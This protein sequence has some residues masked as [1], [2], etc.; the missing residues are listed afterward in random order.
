MLVVFF[1]ATLSSC[2]NGRLDNCVGH[3][4][5]CICPETIKENEK[6]LAL[7]DADILGHAVA[8]SE[9]RKHNCCGDNICSGPE[10][11]ANCVADCPGVT[12]DATCGEEPHSDRGGRTLTFGVGHRA[13]SAQ[14]CCDKCKAHPKH[15]NSW[16]FCGVAVCWG[17]DTG[18]NH[19]FG[20]CWLRKL[21][22]PA[23]PTFG[24]RGIFAASYRKKMLRTR[25]HLRKPR[26]SAES[27]ELSTSSKCRE[28]IHTSTVFVLATVLLAYSMG[29]AAALAVSTRASS[30]VHATSN[31]AFSC[32]DA[33][34]R[35]LI[36]DAVVASDTVTVPF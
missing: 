32:A 5:K 30:H 22:D 31:T 3:P 17:L 21:E 1:A 26:N 34:Q 14:D 20:E 4:W 27:Y 12:T 33:V 29:N 24:Q 28:E 16:T 8:C 10:T 13:S 9:S 19:T 18:W 2:T 36:D 6:L 25:K 7:V 15:C 35:G 11:V 23:Q